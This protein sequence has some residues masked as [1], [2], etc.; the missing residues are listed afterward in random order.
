[1]LPAVWEDTPH[2]DNQLAK[3]LLCVAIVVAAML[4]LGWMI[5]PHVDTV[6]SNAQ[7]NTIEAVLGATL[8]LGLYSALSG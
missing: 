5:Y 2:M 7:F 4:P 1:M 6:V 8:G 3:K